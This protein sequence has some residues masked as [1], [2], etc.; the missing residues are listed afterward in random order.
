MAVTFPVPEGL[1][2]LLR[3]FTI[4]VVKNKPLD[5]EEFAAQYF[6]NI[7]AAMEVVDEGSDSC[8]KSRSTVEFDESMFIGGGVDVD[9]TEEVEGSQK[10]SQRSVVESLKS[11]ESAAVEQP[12]AEEDE[13]CPDEA[14]RC[15]EKWLKEEA[16]AL[17]AE[18]GS[19][20]SGSTSNVAE[21]QPTAAVG[22]GGGSQ[23]VIDP[24]AQDSSLKQPSP[25][26]SRS[27]DLAQ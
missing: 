13:K 7:V 9:L 20:V 21:E 16:D 2:D 1:L 14:A 15:W 6:S 4:E 12:A 26:A 23:T 17:A 11:H 19:D 22:G 18:K 3:D 5:L 10:G 27:R 25:K 24:A 8:S